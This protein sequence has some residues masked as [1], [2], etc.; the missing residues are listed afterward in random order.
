VTILATQNITKKC[1]ACE[2]DFSKLKER[3][4][5]KTDYRFPKDVPVSDEMRR[6]VNAMLGKK[7]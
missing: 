1:R 5:E 2:I 6:T 7:K 4:R 3:H